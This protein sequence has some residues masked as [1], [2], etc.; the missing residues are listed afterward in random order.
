[1]RILLIMPT[2]YGYYKKIC[3]IL[4]KSGNKVY[5]FPDEISLSF[6]D[7]VRRRFSLNFLRKRYESYIMSIP[8]KIENTEINKVVVIFAGRYMEPKNVEFLRNKYDKAEF[9][10]YTWDSIKNFPQIESIYKLFDRSYS[11][12]KQDCKEYGME[13]LPLFY[14]NDCIDEKVIFDVTSLMTFGIAKSKSYHRIIDSLPDNVKL[15]Q[16]LVMKHKSTYLYNKLKSPESFKGISNDAFKFLPLSQSE[17]NLMFA[18]SKAVI[19]CPLEGQNGLTM[20]TFEVLHLKRKLITTNANIKEYDFYSPNNIFVVDGKT[21]I[22]DSFFKDVFDTN[23]VLDSK[24]SIQNFISILFKANVN[25]RTQ[26]SGA[27]ELYEERS[28]I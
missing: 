17:S 25:V 23:I 24:Y 19:D 12:D 21:Q 10:Y 28:T 5:F 3:N 6:T 11:F 18:K 27:I 4:E 7:R 15:N 8:E 2:F 13:F 22:P 1:M 9:V 16:F 20:R 14:S 26:D